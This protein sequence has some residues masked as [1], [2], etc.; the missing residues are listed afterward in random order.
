MERLPK[1]Q[2]KKHVQKNTTNECRIRMRKKKEE[3]G[4]RDEKEMR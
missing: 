3:E 2:E 1:T 4:G